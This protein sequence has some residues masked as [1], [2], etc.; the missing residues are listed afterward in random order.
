M[1]KLKIVWR[2][3]TLAQRNSGATFLTYLS[4]LWLYLTNA[5][6][7]SFFLSKPTHIL[8]EIMCLI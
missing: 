6:F 4:R 7:F 3:L 8:L 2:S 5:F 1:K